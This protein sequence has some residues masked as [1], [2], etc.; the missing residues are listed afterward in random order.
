[1]SWRLEVFMLNTL[2]HYI[3]QA[4]KPWQFPSCRVESY[5]DSCSYHRLVIPSYFT[6]SLPFFI[7]IH[8]DFLQCIL[9]Q[10]AGLTPLYPAHRCLGFYLFVWQGI[11][12][13][14][15]NA[16]TKQCLTTSAWVLPK[17]NSWITSAIIPFLYL[18]EAWKC[19]KL[20]NFPISKVPWRETVNCD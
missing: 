13:L 18:R 3:E 6:S 15:T 7:L 12:F 5:N 2:C 1:M 10:S 11:R 19:L 4:T 20:L 14:L 9:L 8:S 16:F 17:N